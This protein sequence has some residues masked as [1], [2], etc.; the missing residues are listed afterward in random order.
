MGEKITPEACQI[1]NEKW[2]AYGG[3]E[4]IIAVIAGI[5]MANLIDTCTYY[6]GEFC[7]SVAVFFSRPLSH[8][9]RVKKAEAEIQERVTR[10]SKIR[11][12]SATVKPG[13]VDIGRPLTFRQA[14]KEVQRGNSVFAVTWAE[15]K[16][17]ALAAGGFSGHNNKLLIPEID[18]GKENIPGYYYHYHTYDRSGGHVYFL[19]GEVK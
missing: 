15:A 4:V 16:A 2:G 5:A 3:A 9:D 6:V 13:Y 17:V 19:F 18:S 12:W 10:N 14:V 11:Y 1:Q 7:N 8:L